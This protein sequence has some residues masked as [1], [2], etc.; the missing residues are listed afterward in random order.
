VKSLNILMTGMSARSV[1][2]K[3]IRYDF[4]ALS[5]IFQTALEDLGH[6]VDR[7][8]VKVGE[9]AESLAKYDVALVLVNWVS[10]LSSM[11]AHEIGLALAELERAKV[12]TI[13]YFDDW[14]TESLGDDLDHHVGRDHG[15]RHHTESF[16]A[17]DYAGFTPDMLAQSREMYMRII[18]RVHC[19]WPI[20]VPAHPWGDPYKH[21]QVSKRPIVARIVPLDPSPMVRMPNIAIDEPSDRERNWVLA[22]LQNHDRWTSK[23]GNHW[24]LIQMGGVKKKGG[25]LHASTKSVYPEAEVVQQYGYNWGSLV[26]PYKNEGSGWWRPRYTYAL[27]A[28]AI[29]YVGSQVDAELIGPSFTNSLREIETAST[30]DLLGLQVRQREQFERHQYT[31]DQFK[32]MLDDV[33]RND[34]YAG[35]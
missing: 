24:P 31:E 27:R 22:T 29:M 7:R 35:R 3:K 28:G 25:G 5:D 9:T 26:A 21:M 30:M 1:G 23:L 20:I 33:V 6:T 11:H 18:D 34:G 19:P 10:S 2:S 14:R 13:L 4:V 15:W 12:R 32:R 8:A 17:K 16:R